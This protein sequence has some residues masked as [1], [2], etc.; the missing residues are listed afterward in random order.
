MLENH[1]KQADE[2]IKIME[3]SIFS[4]MYCFVEAHIILNTI[5]A[6]QAEILKQ[7]FQFIA[8]QIEIKID[9]IIY[10]RTTPDI[11]M[12][13]IKKRNR[14]EEMDIKTSY[15]NLLH[16]LHDDWLLH[17]KFPSPAPIIILDGNKN[18]AQITEELE[19]KL[20]QF[21]LVGEK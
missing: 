9:L 7:W 21:C 4:A 6:V 13:R 12:E 15:L 18:P 14:K 2:N 19:L 11:L 8:S 1:T 17:N 16:Q 10:L 3:R 5:D 20:H